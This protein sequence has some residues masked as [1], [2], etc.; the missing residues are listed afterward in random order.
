MTHGFVKKTKK[1]PPGEIRR[2]KKY[3]KDFME[4]YQDD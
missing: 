4:R 3:R 1:T 2:A